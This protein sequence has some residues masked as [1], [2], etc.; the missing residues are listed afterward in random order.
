[1]AKSPTTRRGRASDSEPK[2]TDVARHVILPEGIVS[3]G[4]P[5]VRKRLEEMG[6]HFDRWQ[7]DL[8][9]CFLAKRAD[10]SYTSGIDGLFV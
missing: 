7:N 2:L 5:Q 3:T 1:M 9:R 8:G 6:T 4:W 10:G